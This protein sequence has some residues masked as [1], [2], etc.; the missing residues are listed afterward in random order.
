M[1]YNP[2]QTNQMPTRLKVKNMMW[3]VINKTFFRFTPPI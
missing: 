3:K 2:V 1:N